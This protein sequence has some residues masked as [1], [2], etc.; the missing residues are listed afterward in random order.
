MEW[1]V[2]LVMKSGIAEKDTKRVSYFMKE[3]Q[4]FKIY[5][6]EKRVNIDVIAYWSSPRAPKR[7]TKRQ[8]IK[9]VTAPTIEIAPVAQVRSMRV[10]FGGQ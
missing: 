6:S 3:I 2:G 5:T 9:K 7:M 10:V 8:S 1:S 4:L